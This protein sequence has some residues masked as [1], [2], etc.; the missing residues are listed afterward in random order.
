MSNIEEDIKV[1]TNIEKLR[2]IEFKHCLTDREMKAINNVLLEREQ[3][4]KRIQ[5][6]EEERQIVGMP[7]RNKRSGKIGVILHKWESG[8]IAV[9]EKISP[10]VI[11]THENMSTLEV[12]TDKV[13][14]EQ[15]IDNVEGGD[16]NVVTEEDIKIL[17]NYLKNSAYKQSNSD[18]FKNGGWEIVDLE[19]PQAIEHLLLDYK[20]QKQINEEHQK[21]NGELREKVK[22]LEKE[23]RIF[24]LEGSKIKLS[25]YIKENY[26]PKQKIKDFKEQIKLTPIIVG[27][28]RN[29][30][31]L[32]YGIKL[33]KI[34]ACEELLKESE[35]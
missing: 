31:T 33:G 17:E 28:R 11:N 15:T 21:I 26:I 22:E 7:V 8:S 34:K 12:I 30:K 2:R 13:I 25:L 27:G 20:R 3:D 16:K 35:E 18:F 6:L 5:E 32:E 9:L 4:K 1:L 10:R 24:A 19:V 14:Q 29:K 23:N